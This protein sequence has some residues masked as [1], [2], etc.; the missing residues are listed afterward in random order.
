MKKDYYELLDVSKSST[1]EEIKKAYRKMAMKYHPDR[2]QG[3]KKAEDKFKEINEA[4]EVLGDPSKRKMYDQFG[5]A[6]FSQ[7][8]PGGP[9]GP[10]GGFSGGGFDFSDI[11]E[12]IEGLFGGFGSMFGGGR[13]R[14]GGSVN[15][16]QRGRD[17]LVEVSI[18]LEEAFEG[19]GKVIKLN[20]REECSACHG[21]GTEKEGDV[22]TC[23]RCNGRG[24][25]IVSQGIFTVKQTCPQCR[26]NGVVIKNPCKTCGGNGGVVKKRDIKINI[27]AGVDDGT[28]LKLKG[29]GEAGKNNGS[30][31]DLY[32]DIHVQTH[33]R[34]E[35]DGNDLYT[36]VKV[37]FSAMI[38]G[39]E[40]SLQNI[41][42]SKVK[43]KIPSNTENGQVFKMKSLGMKN[44]SGY[45]GRTGDLY[46][47]VEVDVPKKVSSKAKAL[48]RE[49]Q[50][51]LAAK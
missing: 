38:L 20:R 36:K 15:R 7:G 48:L 9:G 34:F 42:R 51:E 46:V 22:V 18:S 40:I 21:K 10:G 4:Y 1:E 24:E 30:K 37:P 12:D 45:F 6:A 43:L 14:S 19:S 41:D 27:P 23:P 49:L 47:V 39:G 25:A 33:S 32:V 29:E 35:R 50:E 44:L 3:D 31:G 13:R 8:G 28:R 26:G 5:H 2:N 17:I 11:M 16:A